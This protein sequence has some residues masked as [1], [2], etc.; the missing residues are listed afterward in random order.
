VQAALDAHER[1]SAQAA[2]LAYLRDAVSAPVHT[3]PFLFDAELGLA[4]YRQLAELL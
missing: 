1:S 4:G 2:Q 3:L